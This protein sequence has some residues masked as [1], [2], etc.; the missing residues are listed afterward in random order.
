MS[1]SFDTLLNRIADYLQFISNTHLFW[2]M[3]NTSYDHDCHLANCIYLEPND[4]KVLLIVA[5]LL[6]PPPERGSGNIKLVGAESK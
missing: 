2:F 6:L 1:Q 3:L 4:Y 5:G